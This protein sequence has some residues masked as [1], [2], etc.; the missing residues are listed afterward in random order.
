M[1]GIEQVSKPFPRPLMSQPDTNI[2]R[3]RA[4]ISPNKEDYYNGCGDAH[5]ISSRMFKQSVGF[6]AQDPK[7][8]FSYDVMRKQ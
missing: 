1:K 7:K 3:L 5:S 6:V 4:D 2:L 8:E